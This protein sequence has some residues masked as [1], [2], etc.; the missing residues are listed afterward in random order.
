MQIFLSVY[1]RICLIF[2]IVVRYGDF[3]DL[4]GVF[5]RFLCRNRIKIDEKTSK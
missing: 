2:V 5:D 3:F 1:L 4:S